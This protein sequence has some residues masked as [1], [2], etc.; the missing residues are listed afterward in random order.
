MSTMYGADV[1]ELRALARHFNSQAERI[2]Q[3]C[4]T[5]GNAIQ[6]RAWAG[7]VAVTFR[8]RWDSEYSR[9]LSAVA[10]RLRDAARDLHRNADDQDRASSVVDSN[11]SRRGTRSTWERTHEADY[12]APKSVADFVRASKDM[13]DK[14][15]GLRIQKVFCEDGSYRYIVYIGGSGSTRDG[16]W[17]GRLG[18][19]NNANAIF[20]L[21][22]T[23][24]SGIRDKIRSTIDDPQA[25]VALVGFSQGGMIAQQLADEGSFNTS[26]VLTYGSPIAPQARNYGGADILRLAHQADITPAIPT[27]I[28]MMGLLGTIHDAL[29]NERPAPGADVRFVAGTLKLGA[30]NHD[31]YAWVAEQFDLSDAAAHR[32]MQEKLLRFSGRVI[33]DEK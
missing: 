32:T 5:V 22:G 4:M 13:T 18:W 10:A 1:A 8:H 31:D 33:A 14:D 19:E 26:T 20:A 17:G 7:P 11:T 15:D 24:L 25:E 28:G 23:T 12:S 9:K 30:H 29:G 27:N 6:I 3:D 16:D 21:D 2:E